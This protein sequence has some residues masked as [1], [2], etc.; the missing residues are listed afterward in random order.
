LFMITCEEEREEKGVLEDFLVSAWGNWMGNEEL[1][2]RMQ[3]L[4]V[5]YVGSGIWQTSVCVL[6]LPLS[7]V[8]YWVCDITWACFLNCKMENN[9]TYLFFVC[10]L[11]AHWMYSV[12][13][14]V[15][16]HDI[17]YYYSERVWTGGPVQMG[18][19]CGKGFW[20]WT[21]VRTKKKNTAL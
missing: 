8:W 9:T 20:E 7:A 4:M 1:G 14:S 3:A 10:E 19:V 6:T 11:N 13:N 16:T 18:E 12:W 17:Y 15:G 5:M 2:Q 21:L